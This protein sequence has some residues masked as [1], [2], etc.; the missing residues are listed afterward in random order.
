MG[1]VDE[2]EYENR[3]I[4]LDSVKYQENDLGI[5]VRAVLEKIIGSPTIP[6]VFIGGEHVGGATEL[7]DAI[8]NGTAQE[9]LVQCGVAFDTDQ[10]ID[11]YELM[12]GW[13]QPRKSA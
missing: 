13:L 12:P 4:D 1:I 7:F 8:Q 5:K 9:H 6:Q 11:P 10:E 2:P 3:T